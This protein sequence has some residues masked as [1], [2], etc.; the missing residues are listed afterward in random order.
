MPSISGLSSPAPKSPGGSP[1]VMP[2]M[3]RSTGAWRL[4]RWHDAQMQRMAENCSDSVDPL[5]TV[6]REGGPFHALHEPGRSPLSAYLERL[7]KTGRAEGAA[8]LR[9]KYAAWLGDPQ[10]I[11]AAKS[12]RK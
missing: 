3:S 6:M 1:S 5:W 7:E 4:M 12:N 11:V 9:E 8:K 10:E 2:R